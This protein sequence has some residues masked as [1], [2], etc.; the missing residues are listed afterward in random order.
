MVSELTHA[1]DSDA[2]AAK[3]LDEVLKGEITLRPGQTISLKSWPTIEVKLTGGK[4]DGSITSATAKALVELQ[5][6]FDHAYL[7]LARPKGRRLT[8]AEKQKTAI[9]AKVE[10]G[11]SFLTIDLNPALTN[12]ATALTDKMTPEQIVITILGLGMIAG[13]T[14][15]AKQYVKSR[16]ERVGRA[17][18]LAANVSLSDNE[19]KRLEIVTK[20]MS[21]QPVL[22][23]A[24]EDFDHARDEMLRSAS[25]AESINFDGVTLT[26][27]QSRILPRE[28]RSASEEAQLNG[29]YTVSA[30]SW[31]ADG[32]E[33]ILDLRSTEETLEFRATLSTRSLM[34]KDKDLLAAAGWDRKPIYIS[35]NAR[36]LRGEVTKATI[37]G[38]DWEALRKKESDEQ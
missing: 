14:V 35:I 36:M 33:A 3:V 6:A 34:Q 1:I 2:G 26:G 16:A 37:V 8:D 12:L 38:F 20:A 10:K 7:R 5:H 11:S 17:Q 27:E 13:S 30:V 9:S 4:Y 28:P 21:R 23:L 24:H 22:R 15:I 19:T 29:T 31:S 25:D 18:E 32:G